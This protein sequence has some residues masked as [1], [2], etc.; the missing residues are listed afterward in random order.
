MNVRVRQDF[1]VEV[2]LQSRQTLSQPSTMVVI[3]ERDRT[4]DLLITLPLLPHQTIPNQV[5][6]ELGTIVRP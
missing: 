6:Q 3:D 4:D 5:T 1:I 2:M